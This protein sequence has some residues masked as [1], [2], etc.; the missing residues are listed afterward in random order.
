[1]RVRTTPDP[2][3]IVA[4]SNELWMPA[5]VDGSGAMTPAATAELLAGTVSTSVATDTDA[6]LLIVVPFATGRIWV[7]RSIE[8]ESP[9]AITAVE[10]H[11]MVAATVHVKL[12]LVAEIGAKPEGNE[13]AMVTEPAGAP[14]LPRW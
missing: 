11:V 7:T 10:T 6:V 2:A 4:H 12:V 13:S 9:G 8:T 1:M 14:D 5:P 3:I